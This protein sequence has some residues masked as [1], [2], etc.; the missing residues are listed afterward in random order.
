M[1]EAQMQAR[2]QAIDYM[3]R[4]LQMNPI[5]DGEEIVR[6]RMKALG[7]AKPT[8]AAQ[9][10]PVEVQQADRRKVLAE[11]EAVRSQFWSMPIDELKTKLS[12]LDSQG[13]GDLDVAIGRLRVVANRR[14]QFPE[15]AGKRGFDGDFF[16][17]L[18]EVLIRSPRDTAVLREKVL[19][20]FRNRSRRKSG[21]QMV[22]LLK[23]EMPAIYQLEADWFD[24]L[25]RQ[26]AQLPSIRF[27]SG[28]SGES[29]IYAGS[30]AR[31]YWWVAVLVMVAVRGFWS[32]SDH[33]R[34]NSRAPS[35]PSYPYQNRQR[36]IPD[37]YQQP[38]P[39]VPNAG[40][41][42]NPQTNDPRRGSS[43]G[44][45]EGVWKPYPD[46]NAPEPPRP[47][48]Y[49]PLHPDHYRSNF[50]SAPKPNPS[51]GFPQPNGRFE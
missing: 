33:N 30:G 24:S 13:F 49:D 51:P 12:A 3:I 35:S 29:T 47:W 5:Q 17:A 7:L 50:P 4:L 27:T 42:Q 23:T 9:S 19:S 43:F 14:A 20:T 44:V 37:K 31:S 2:Q 40:G 34:R 11:L 18:K 39:Y 26:K 8:E 1:N 6:A 25:C 38:A 36:Y 41:S 45:D 32:A 48:G 16:S 46:S 22:A 15:L 28:G 10:A 21:R